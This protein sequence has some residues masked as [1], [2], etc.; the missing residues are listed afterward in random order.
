[1]YCILTYIAP[2]SLTAPAP[3]YVAPEILKNCPYDQSADMWSVGVII[4]V[5]ICGYP[6]FVDENQSVLF[7]KIRVGDWQFHDKAWGS[8]SKEAKEMI[9]RLLVVNPLQRWSAKECL[10]SPWMTKEF[11]KEEEAD[12]TQSVVLM[13]RRKSQLRGLSKGGIWGNSKVEQPPSK[14]MDAVE[15]LLSRR[16]VEPDV[17]DTEYLQQ[18]I[19]SEGDRVDRFTI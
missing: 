5:L 7:Q 1:M 4:Y 3:T 6:P 9:K 10:A 15:M 2:L 12:L 16:E 13:R 17:E 19:K 14:S 8:I 11:A 18:T